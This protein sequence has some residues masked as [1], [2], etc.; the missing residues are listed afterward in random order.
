M[1]LKSCYYK[2]NFP[3]T[4]IILRYKQIHECVIIALNQSDVPNTGESH[5]PLSAYVTSLYLILDQND[6]NTIP[7]F[8]QVSPTNTRV[9]LCW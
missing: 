7:L 8:F 6:C 4:F 2:V 9:N 3:Q 5:N 1:G